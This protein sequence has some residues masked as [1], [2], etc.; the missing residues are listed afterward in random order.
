[1]KSVPAAYYVGLE[2]ILSFPCSRHEDI[3]GNGVIAPPIIR[4]STCYVEV[5]KMNQPPSLL[6]NPGKRTPG[7]H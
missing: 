1:M 6:Q 3:R 5:S 2:K 7:I 4:H